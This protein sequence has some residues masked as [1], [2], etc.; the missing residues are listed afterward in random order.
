[1]GWR[2]NLGQATIGRKHALTWMFVERMTGFEPATSTLA[3]HQ[4]PSNPY[5]H[6]RFRTAQSVEY[7]PV[8]AVDGIRDGMTTS[9]PPCTV[10]SDC[11]KG[12]SSEGRLQP[13][14]L[15]DAAGDSTN[16]HGVI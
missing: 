13:L 11:A 12:F 2:D 14:I 15:A 3:R 9:R 8:R 6:V 10:Q 5:G 4:Q 16:R 7:G 1:M